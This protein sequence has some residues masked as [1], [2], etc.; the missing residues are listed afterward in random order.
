MSFLSGEVVSDSFG[1]NVNFLIT[2][3]I[4]ILQVTEKEEQVLG[5]RINLRT[6]D[7]APDVLRIAIHLN[8]EESDV[9]LLEQKL[10]FVINEYL[11]K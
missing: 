10:R 11:N 5:K 6:G 7:F 9:M 3:Q 4:Q 1:P 8:V 2:L